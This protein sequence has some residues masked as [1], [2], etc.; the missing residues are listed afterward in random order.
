MCGEAVPFHR[1]SLPFPPCLLLFRAGGTQ[2]AKRQ[3]VREG[4]RWGQEG[5]KGRRIRFYKAV[6][7]NYIKCLYYNWVPL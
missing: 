2:P 6:Y 3:P 1:I 4:T 7:Y 5:G